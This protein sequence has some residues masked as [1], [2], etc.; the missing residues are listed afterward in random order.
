M[1]DIKAEPTDGC[2]NLTKHFHATTKHPLVRE[3]NL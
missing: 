2:D 3:A 1:K